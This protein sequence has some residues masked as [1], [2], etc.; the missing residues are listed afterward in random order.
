M[1]LAQGGIGNAMG[2]ESD[3]RQVE[4]MTNG[5]SNGSGMRGR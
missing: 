5:N 4:A 3:F 1:L 2:A